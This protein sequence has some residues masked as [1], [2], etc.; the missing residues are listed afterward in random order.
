MLTE[1]QRESYR[2]NG[3]LRVPAFVPADACALIRE[4][5]W[6]ALTAAHGIRQDDPG[7]WD[8]TMPRRLGKHF[9]PDHGEALGS[10][11]MIE[12]IDAVLGPGNWHRPTS[13]AQPLP[14]FPSNAPWEVPGRMWHLDY[15][16]RA[17]PGPHFAVK[18]LCLL[19]PV[20]PRGGG[21]LLLAGS[22]RLI[23]RLAAS[24]FTGSSTRVRKRLSADH[25]WLRELMSRD[26]HEPD[27]TRRFMADGTVIDG[28]PLRVVEFSGGTGDV[29]LFHPWLLHNVS[30]NCR[31][32]PR[33]M[34]G[35]NINTA[36]G[37]RLYQPDAA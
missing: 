5:L 32:T 33:L 30:P 18:V 8:Q 15:P 29:V 24:G 17:G 10:A 4:A 26:H 21:T 31:Q 1:S 12:L 34:V 20:E 35:Q 28:V 14:L 6:R 3:F 27:R 25:P 23:E 13:W 7:T 37:E 16:V 22:H 36:A 9:R 11:A 19:A 2:Q